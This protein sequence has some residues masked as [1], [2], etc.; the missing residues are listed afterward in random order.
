[1]PVDVA[2]KP[3]VEKDLRSLPASIVR[4]V[5]DQVDILKVNP[6]PRRAVKLMGAEDLYRIRIGAYRLIYGIDRDAKAVPIHY[7][8]HRGA[9]DRR[10]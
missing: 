5:F 4:R 9:A 1:M 8:R 7:V 6:L 3:S 10:L 2:F